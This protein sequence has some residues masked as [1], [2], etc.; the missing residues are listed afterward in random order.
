MIDIHNYDD[1]LPIS[2]I[3]PHLSKRDDF[4]YNMVFPMLDANEPKEIIVVSDM[5]KAPRQRN[6]GME[7]A[8]QPYV[9]FCDDDNVLPKNYLQT[10][11]DALENNLDYDYAYT[12][13]LLINTHPLAEPHGIYKINSQPFDFNRLLQGNYIDTTSLQR[14]EKVIKWDESLK[15][16]Q[17]YWYYLE[18]YLTQ[19]SYGLYVNTIFFMSYG[20]DEGISSVNNSYSDAFNVIQK[21]LMTWK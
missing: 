2:V 6:L 16:L 17:D 13:K 8:T 18:K 5:G 11:Y 10:L 4:F 9:M 14:R 19:R 15:R 12:D 3:V 7:K 20:I 1:G 21:R